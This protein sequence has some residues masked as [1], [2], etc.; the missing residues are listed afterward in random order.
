MNQI[1][2]EGLARNVDDE[3]LTKPE[4][5]DDLRNIHKSLKKMIL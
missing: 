5:F 1:S 4:D 2:T 3:L